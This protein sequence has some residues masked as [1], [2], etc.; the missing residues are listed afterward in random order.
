MKILLGKGAT[1][2]LLL[3]DKFIY[4]QQPLDLHMIEILYVLYIYA[5]LYIYGDIMSYY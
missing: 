3:F 4:I 1:L 2:T 5:L